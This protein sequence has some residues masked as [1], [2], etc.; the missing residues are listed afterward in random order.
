MAIAEMSKLNLV[1]LLYE[2]DKIL[3]A[4]Q[5][6]R[7]A[8]VKT[9]T[10]LDNT[11]VCSSSL[12]ELEE[13]IRVL[14]GALDYLVRGVSGFISDNKIK[15]LKIE[16]EYSLSYSEFLQAGEKREQIEGYIARITTLEE[17]KKELEASL[18]KSRRLE[19]TASIYRVLKQPF[20]ILESG[21]RVI[22]RLGTIPVQAFEVLEKEQEPLFYISKL[23]IQENEALVFAAFHK[24]LDGDKILQGASFNACPFKEG[25][26]ESVYKTAVA[27]IEA[28]TDGLRDN[29][30]ELF[31]MREFIKPLRIYCDYLKFE[32]EKAALAEKLR[33]T[34]ETFLLEAYVPTESEKVVGE[35]IDGV[36]NAAYYEFS[37]PAEDEIPPT[38]YLNNAIVSNFETITDMYSPPSSKEFDPNTVMAFFY[39][40]FLGFIMGD[41]GYGLIMLLGGGALWFKLRSKGGGLARLSGVFAVGGI[42]AIVWG[43]LFNSIF[44][45]KFGYPAVLP[46]ARE[47]RWAF[48]GIQV[49]SVL[50]ISLEL[51]VVHL[52]AG[53]ICKTVQCFRRGYIGDGICEGVIWAIFSF[54]VGIAI[55]GL[56]DELDFIEL[57][58]GGGIVAAAA[59]VMAMLTA[60]RKEKFFGKF[61]K[62][63]GAAYGIINYA[64]DILSY[65]RLYG[66]ML[67]GAVIAQIISDYAVSGMNG[68]VGFLFSGNPML[69]VLGIFILVVGHAFNFAIGLLGAYIHDARLQYVEFYGRFFEGDGELFAPLGSRHDYVRLK[70]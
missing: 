24:A 16:S 70:K 47:D 67:S 69:I 57:A 68:N 23:N 50:I 43:L 15:D 18:L 28:A 20:S 26:G 6:T 33:A 22:Y 58:Y 44:G 19:K 41:V 4:L 10:V 1:A 2:R 32:L 37:K 39:S 12:S 7:A 29:A 40:L 52:F 35:A 63:F 3:N 11:Q 27:E 17:Q 65:A 5:R 9:H 46:D 14:E 59:L 42:F 34:Q 13:R 66:L 56:V 48:M 64:S 31:K 61:T 30:D 51:G 21:T 38:L 53:Y 54:G 62:G 49:P 55:A 45:I 60:G 36:T 8:E 25:S